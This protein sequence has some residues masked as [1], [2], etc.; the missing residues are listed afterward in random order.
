MIEPKNLIV[1][2]PWVDVSMSGGPYEEYEQV[3][4]MLGVAGLR[5]MGKVWA[6]D[7]SSKDPLVSPIF[8]NNVGLPNM[9]IFVGT[10]EIFYPDISKFYKKLKSA[11]VQAQLI[12]GN[13]MDHVYPIYPIPEAKEAI[14]LIVRTIETNLF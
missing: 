12:V 3:D 2:S 6:D 9:L 8:G 7:K 11:S 14:D 5:E 1:M 4:P 10:H 13:K